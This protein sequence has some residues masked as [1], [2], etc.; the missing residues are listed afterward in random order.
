MLDL[1]ITNGRILDGT[2]A[3][4]FRGD[5]G[6]RGDAIVAIGDLANTPAKNTIDARNRIVSPG[7]VD[8]LGWSQETVIEDPHLEA[9]VRQGITTHLGGEGSS[10]GPVKSDRV[11]A[12]TRWATL[13]DYLDD[14]D[15]RGS[16]I[17]FA[18]LLGTSNPRAMVL[19]DVNVQPTAEQMREMEAIVEQ[20]MRDGAMGLGSSLIYVPAMY[21]TTEELINLSRVA[22]R[23][24]GVYFSHIRDEG[25]RIDSALDEA[26]RIG[27]ESGIPI[28]IWHLKIGGRTN[29]GKMPAIVAR[30]A[31]ARA[32]GLDVSANVYPYAASGTG[33][34]TLAP[35]WAMDG[36]YDSFQE[37]LKNPEDRARIAEALR[38]QFA[39][40]GLRGIYVTQ[41]VNTAQDKFEKKFIEEIAE[42]MAVPVEEALM[43]LFAENT[44]SPRVIF[45]SMN[46]D[47]VRYALKTPWVSVGSDASAPSDQ[48][49]ADNTAVHPRAYGTFPRVLGRYS[50]DEKLFTLEEAVRK[51]TSQAAL[52]ANIHDRGIL[53]EGM[54]A[55]IVIFDP[56]T[57]R[58]LATFEDPHHFSE[59]ISDVIVNGVSVLRDGAMTRA[60][61][62]QTIR[63]R[64]YVK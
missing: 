37:R 34:S 62:G 19:G 48:A 22:H 58:D 21:S 33:L 2:G 49:R 28:N 60:L 15:L 35:D 31:A 14:V 46:E 29:W 64:G 40:R 32:E 17:N 3:P 61:P 43:T 18:M 25:D 57:V 38:A 45:F 54:K 36:G 1:K 27:R 9:T 20:A 5:V 42:M 41:I 44:V 7:F 52:R 10:P 56:E 50:R 30:I 11:K 24:G 63:G 13:G 39:K 47:D 51:I 55:D 16:S 8:L 26:F 23:Y 6:V 59:G 12:G 53:R 4:W